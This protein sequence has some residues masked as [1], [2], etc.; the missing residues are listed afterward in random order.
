MN[1]ITHLKRI[2]CYGQEPVLDIAVIKIDLVPAFIGE[3]IWQGRQTLNN[4]SCNYYLIAVVGRPI[5]EKYRL[6]EEGVSGSFDPVWGS[7]ARE[8]FF[9][10]VM[11]IK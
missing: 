1:E 10:D 3:I 11:F 7:K 6:L 4:S 9:E 5:K 2:Y 8:C